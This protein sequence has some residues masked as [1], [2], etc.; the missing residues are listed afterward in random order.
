MSD[1]APLASVRSLLFAPGNEER[2]LRGALES[3]AD[4]RGRPRRDHDRR[5]GRRAGARD[6]RSY[7]KGW[8]MS[9]AAPKEWRGRFF[10]DF[11]VGDVYK[12]VF[13]GDTLWAQSEVLDLRESES[14]WT[15]S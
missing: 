7:T 2:K 15:V 3:D 6:H 5:A 4:G 12:P 13:V 1:D 14:R 11:D 8:R 9:E 10:E